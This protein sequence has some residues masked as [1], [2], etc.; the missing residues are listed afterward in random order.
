MSTFPVAIA[1][2][3]VVSVVEEEGEVVEKKEEEVVDDALVT[4]R[5]RLKGRTAI[6][7]YKVRLK[8]FS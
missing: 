2:I 7:Q 4:A 6:G 5:D 8:W 3:F 1:P